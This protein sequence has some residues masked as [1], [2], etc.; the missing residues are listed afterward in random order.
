MTPRFASR[1]RGGSLDLTLGILDHREMSLDHWEGFGRPSFH[2]AIIS[3]LCLFSELSNV[4]FVV[5]LKQFQI[6]P[7]EVRG[8]DVLSPNT[9]GVE[10]DAFPVGQV[11]QLLVRLGV[12]GYH[13]CADRFYIGAF[14][15][16]LGLFLIRAFLLTS[17]FRFLDNVLVL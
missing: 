7:V 9:P 1:G 13:A 4:I 12:V 14:S 6:L 16:F 10:L 11:R 5:H 8:S 2:V 3:A 17:A 15:L